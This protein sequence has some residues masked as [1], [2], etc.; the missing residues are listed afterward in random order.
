[1]RRWRGLVW[2]GGVGVGIE[3]PVCSCYEFSSYLRTYSLGYRFEGLLAGYLELGLIA[4]VAGVTLAGWLC[5]M[6]LRVHG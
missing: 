5:G 4:G 3:I 6:G 2:L 1:M